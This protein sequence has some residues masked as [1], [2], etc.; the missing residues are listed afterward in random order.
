MARTG[1]RRGPSTSRATIL[2]VAA[3]RFA[4]GGYEG[5]SLR[6]VAAEAGVDPAVV[7]HFFGSKE[8][9]FRAAVGWPFDPAGMLAELADGSNTPEPMAT[10][11]ARSFFGFWDDPTAGPKLLAMLRSA[12]THDASAA[13]LREF[14]MR[15]L[16][17][18][19]SGL[20][21][22]PD[23]ALRVDLAAGQLIGLAL[24]RYALRVEP[25]ASATVDELVDRCAPAL[26]VILGSAGEPAPEPGTAH[27]TS[28]VDSRGTHER[29]RR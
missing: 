11:L 7:L 22:S 17:G 9:L 5:T 10:H 4:E 25:I 2:K 14:L 15:R 26:A 6:S 29:Q 18:R 16:F 8:G 23:A 28:H 3:Q 24:L 12:M 20:L 27:R 13:L 21:H 1:R 19:M